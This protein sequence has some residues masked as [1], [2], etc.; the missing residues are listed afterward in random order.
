MTIDTPLLLN[1]T[2]LLVAIGF[3]LR[4]L[5]TINATDHA[6]RQW[7]VWLLLTGTMLVLQF[8]RFATPAGFDIHYLGA[9]FLTLTLG[10]RRAVISLALII[11]ATTPFA[12]LGP[13]LLLHAFLPAWLTCRLLDLV[14]AHL[15]HNLFVFLLGIGCIG[16]F[17]IMA[18]QLSLQS[19][20]FAF[21][22]GS[23]QAGESLAYALLL[24]V[25]ESVFEGMVLT[26]L[27]VYLPAAVTLFEDETWLDYRQGF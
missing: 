14:K 9:P 11:T 24:A 8:M 18:M 10:Y 17:A 5:A 27:V 1:A 21:T 12:E 15:P 20:L 7:L 3:L 26:V 2:A 22:N 6:D 13:Q 16:L 19:L 4:A 23:E 25:G